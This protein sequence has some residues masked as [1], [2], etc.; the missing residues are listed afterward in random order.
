MATLHLYMLLSADVNV[1]IGLAYPNDFSAWKEEGLALQYSPCGGGA[2]VLSQEKSLYTKPQPIKCSSFQGSEGL[3][4]TLDLRVTT[5]IPETQQQ[6]QHSSFW[7][8]T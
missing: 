6:H 4:I 8:H 3:N 2:L 7:N 5:H 1:H